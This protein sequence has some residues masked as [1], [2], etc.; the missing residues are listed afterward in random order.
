MY[1]DSNPTPSM[2]G[3]RVVTLTPSTV[4]YTPI[5]KIP[6]IVNN[7][8]AVESLPIQYVTHVPALSTPTQLT[9]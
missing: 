9:T 3:L 5:V 4:D 8:T 6:N 7:L 2:V 1:E